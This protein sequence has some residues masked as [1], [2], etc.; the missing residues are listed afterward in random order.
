M[1]RLK[2]VRTKGAIPAAFRGPGRIDQALTLLVAPGAGRT[3]DSGYWKKAKKQLKA[4]SGGK[5]AYCEAPTAVVAHGDVEHF[6]PKSVYWW[7]AYCYDNYLFSCQI[8]NQS[9][10]KD[11][12]PLEDDA[13]RLPAP[14][15]PAG[16][17][18]AARREFVRLFAPDPLEDTEGMPWSDFEAAI[19]AE[20]ASLVNPYV[21]DP[22]PRFRWEADAAL[23]EVAARARS[24]AED[25]FHKAAETFYGLNRPELALERWK[26]YRKL[27]VFVQAFKAPELD[28][29]TRN[30]VR[31]MIVEMM[32]DNAP[33][34]GMCRYFVR[35]EWGLGL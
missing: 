8:C 14:E 10:K 25:R 11:E 35:V 31:E 28:A 2:R 32:G 9:F 30:E 6:R 13:R 26:T 27:D 23:Q 15:L 4:E 18:D 12:F 19:R 1:I 33:F 3:F 24:E 21:E 22:E 16:A 5:C 17:E 34:A 7:L 29:G 20:G